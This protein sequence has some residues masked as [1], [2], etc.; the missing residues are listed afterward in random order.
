MFRSPELPEPVQQL[1]RAA[2][3]VI[4][5]IDSS[6]TRPSALTTERSSTA[7]GPLSSI[8]TA[9]AVGS[10]PGITA[11]SVGSTV[12]EDLVCGRL[13]GV[14]SIH[15]QPGPAL[16]AQSLRLHTQDSSASIIGRQCGRR[17]DPDTSL[18][19]CLHDNHS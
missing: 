15:F 10:K 12:N 17:T 18:P 2:L 6:L 1:A 16:A 7:T 4:D 19:G 11:I 3:S 14:Y 13:T 8:T 5:T 9:G